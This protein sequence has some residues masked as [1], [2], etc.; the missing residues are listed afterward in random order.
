MDFELGTHTDPSVTL[1]AKM[2]NAIPV[3]SSTLVPKSSG[4]FQDH[5][6]RKDRSKRDCPPEPSSFEA[7]FFKEGII[8]VG[9]R[10]NLP[11]KMI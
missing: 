8:N 10:L 4:Q 7:A 1:T 9:V 6:Q 2:L 3:W 11:T 5:R